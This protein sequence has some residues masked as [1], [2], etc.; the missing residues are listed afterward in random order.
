MYIY[1][2]TCGIVQLLIN[3]LRWQWRINQGSFTASGSSLVRCWISSGYMSVSNQTWHH[4]RDL[5]AAAIS[6]ENSRG[7]I[8]SIGAVVWQVYPSMPKDSGKP[9]H[10]EHVLVY[11]V[12]L[13]GFPTEIPATFLNAHT[14]KQVHH[15]VRIVFMALVFI[16]AEGWLKIFHYHLWFTEGTFPLVFLC[17]NL[18]GW[19][20]NTHLVFVVTHQICWICW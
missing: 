2:H 5:G 8:Q 4:P 3:K 7:R 15:P 9:E 17:W 18:K 16:I 13:F 14:H 19:W 20:L 6:D 1:I 12:W 10:P 11:F